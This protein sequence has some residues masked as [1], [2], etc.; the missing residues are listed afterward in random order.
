MIK[1]RIAR[2]EYNLPT[3]NNAYNT[4]VFFK[5]F[6]VKC[7][8]FKDVKVIIFAKYGMAKNYFYWLH[9][10]HTYAK[11][12]CKKFKSYTLLTI[13]QERSTV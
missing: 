10:W 4:I 7:Y 8:A 12:R 5:D 6:V 13:K 2:V 9:N 3:Q 1:S 11:K